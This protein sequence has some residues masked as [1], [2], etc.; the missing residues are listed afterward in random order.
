M[1]NNHPLVSIIIVTYNAESTVI[2]TLESAFG[3]SYDNVEIILSDD[4]SSDNTVKVV[5]SWLEQDH[6]EPRF[7]VKLLEA[8]SNQGV[9]RNFNKAINNSS[10]VYIKII[11]GD[12]KLLP[13]C[14]A[15]F[16]NYIN[17]HPSANFVASYAKVYSE[18]FDEKNCVSS[19][20]QSIVPSFFTESADVQL[21]KMAYSI[22]VSAPTMFFSRKVFD[23][24]GG[25]DVRYPYE[26]HPF[27]INILE[28]GEKIHFLP[29]DTVAYRVHASTYNSDLKLFNYEFSRASKQFR[30][31]KCYKYYGIRQKIAVKSYYAFLSFLE[32]FNLNKKTKWLYPIYKVINGIIWKFGK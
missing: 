27:Y 13:S 14:C 28:H 10:G 26:D 23:L 6:S 19:S 9:C 30:E 8:E 4:C 29:K 17:E 21:R 12:D 31:E 16:V 24:V 1:D 11:A 22:F 32:M 20:H 25:F 15:D 7:S 3:Q 2:E 5:Q 18:T